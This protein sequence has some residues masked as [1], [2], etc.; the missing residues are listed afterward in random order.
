MYGYD[1][2]YLNIWFL[3][4][5][6]ASKTVFKQCKQQSTECQFK[7]NGQQDLTLQQPEN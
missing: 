7:T 6:Y 3:F 2:I 5:V 4:N 1:I